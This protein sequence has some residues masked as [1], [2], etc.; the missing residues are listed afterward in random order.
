VTGLRG[1]VLIT[2]IASLTPRELLPVSFTSPKHL[3]P[4]VNYISRK[5]GCLL[6]VDTHDLKRINIYIYMT[7]AKTMD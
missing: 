6:S 4:F 5:Q 2:H 7:G 3:P 1:I